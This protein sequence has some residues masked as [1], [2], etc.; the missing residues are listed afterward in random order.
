LNGLINAVLAVLVFVVFVVLAI[1]ITPKKSPK[2]TAY[3]NFK[4]NNQN[5]K[6]EKKQIPELEEKDFMGD[7]SEEDGLFLGIDPF[8]PE[9]LEEENNDEDF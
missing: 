1:L 9:E 6:D 7:E 5:P 8:F 3:S 2:K 4:P